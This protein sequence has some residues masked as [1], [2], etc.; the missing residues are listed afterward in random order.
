MEFPHSIITA[1]NQGNFVICNLWISDTL[2]WL[3]TGKFACIG[4]AWFLFSNSLDDVFITR[5][6]CDELARKKS[7]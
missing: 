6:N 2:S 5:F 4:K 7:G 1:V 3:F